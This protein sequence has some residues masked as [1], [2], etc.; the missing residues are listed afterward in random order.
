MLHAWQKDARV[1]FTITEVPAQA[2][3]RGQVQTELARL[4]NWSFWE[5]EV[6]SNGF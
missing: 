4:L 2:R 5:P 6:Q 1:L 3:Q